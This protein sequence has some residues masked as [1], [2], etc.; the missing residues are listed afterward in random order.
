MKTFNYK[1]EY[2][3]LLTPKIVNY[4]TAIH[5][6]NINLKQNLITKSESN[7]L[8]ELT[9]NVKVQSTEA[10]S[11]IDG[12]STSDDQ[13][14]K[15]ALNKTIPATKSD[16]EIAG[17]CYVL[18]KISDSYNYIPP[19]PS[20]I[21]QIH[22]DLYNYSD[23][24]IALVRFNSANK[25]AEAMTALC[26]AYEEAIA[27]PEID[28]LLLIPIF[29]LDFLLIHPFG[30]SDGRVSRLLTLLLLNRSGYFIGKYVSIDRLIADSRD[31]YYKA[32]QESSDGWND[33]KNDY[34]PFVM[35]MFEII[36]KAYSELPS[37]VEPTAPIGSSKS[38]RIRNVIKDTHD[39]I[40]RNEIMSRCPDISQITVQ[41]TLSE[42]LHEGEII[43][44][45]GGRYTSYSWNKEKERSY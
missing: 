22:H 17:Y 21:A 14:K 31:M 6:S 20:V 10:S 37:N 34:T 44:I 24:N 30:D 43:K 9:E 5:E 45:G 12:I 8:H 25:I 11:R 23:R 42:L 41:R 4:L 27:D 28:Q 33:N 18:K 15:L 13:I 35:Y 3:K 1:S 40:T 16:R 29:T 32:I 19:V 38:E 26:R 36:R 7:A 39:K 2:S